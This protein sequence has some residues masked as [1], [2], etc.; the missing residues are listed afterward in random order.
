MNIYIVDAWMPFPYSEYGGVTAV[1]AEDREQCMDI[2]LRR[3]SEFESNK[4]GDDLK[5][6]V[7]QTVVDAKM[8]PLTGTH[9]P[10]VVYEFIT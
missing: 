4:Y 1:I 7:E 2:I 5:K 6:M 8:Y 10:G 3:A 9:A